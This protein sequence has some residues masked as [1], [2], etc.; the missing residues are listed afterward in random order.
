MA[1]SPQVLMQ[2]AVSAFT[3]GDLST[4]ARISDQLITLA[5]N[6]VNVWLLRGRVAARSSRWRQAE[7]ALDRAARI[8][9]KEAEVPFARAMMRMRQGRVVEAAELLATVERLKPNHS[10]AR[11]ARAECLRQLGQPQKAI[12]LLGRHPDSPSQ[13][14]TV[15][16]ALID[17]GDLAAAEKV[18]RDAMGWELNSN[19]TAKQHMM[20]RLGQLKEMQG[21]YAEAF[22]CFTR[23]RQGLR[24]S[25]VP[26]D[27]Q[28]EI[29]RVMSSF[30]A[31]TIA[32]LP[33][34]TVRSRRPIFIVGM[35]RSGT[36]LLEKMIASHPMGAG[37]GETNAFRNQVLPFSQKAAEGRA[38]PEMI[39]AITTEELDAIATGYLAATEAYVIP[40]VERVA[41]KHLQNWIF[42]GLIAAAFPDATIV[43]IERDPLDTG[44]SCFER[45][46]PAA[47]QWCCDAENVGFMIAIN[48]WLMAHWHAVMPGRMLRIRY[49]DLVRDPAGTIRPV[50][51]AAGLP[52]NEAVLKQH[53]RASAGLR[54]PPP[55]LS[56][57]QVKRPIYDT[58]VGR[59]AR[60]GAIL[61]P[62][63][64]YYESTRAQL[65][66]R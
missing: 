1:D 34:P 44:L 66:L 23:A 9:P 45:L 62:M 59:A 31:E 4:A 52:W 17:L 32:K 15:S 35:P 58:S 6:D 8:N 47:M 3:V 25:F 65:G 38:W 63:R 26:S 50:L 48:E 19:S 40:G 61:D 7:D 14:V 51:D 29:A 60:F 27:A 2:R 37:A 10:E 55:T 42:A 5:P 49:E 30:S 13:A 39:A 18:L 43:H 41:D 36:T 12:E 57:D 28:R 33:Q 11:S 16:E 20:R 56:A 21:N 22:A 54:E 53:E 64:T 46:V 24:V